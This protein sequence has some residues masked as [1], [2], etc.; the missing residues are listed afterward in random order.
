MIKQAKHKKH[1]NLYED[2]TLLNL[3]KR[4]FKWNGPHVQ[5]EA[6]SPPIK[7]ASD[8]C[9]LKLKSQGVLLAH[10]KTHEHSNSTHNWTKC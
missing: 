6:R 10:M 4:G 2:Q 5:P 7:F 1:G 8:T 9:A 3:K